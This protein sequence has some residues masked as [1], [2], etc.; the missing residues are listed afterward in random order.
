M[1]TFDLSLLFLLILTIFDVLSIDLSFFTILPGLFSQFLFY[2]FLYW[3]ISSKSIINLDSSLILGWVELSSCRLTKCSVVICCTLFSSEHNFICNDSSS[4]ETSSCRES[5][6]MVSLGE[7]CF[8]DVMEKTR[9]SARLRV[10][11]E[12]Y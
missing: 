6:S 9:E 11:G 3:S 2:L 7:K 4:F 1:K 5:R 8:W 12:N 10:L